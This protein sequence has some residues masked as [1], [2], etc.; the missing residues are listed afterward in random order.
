MVYNILY[1][2]TFLGQKR[3]EIFASFAEFLKRKW[4]GGGGGG[5]T[6]FRSS[7]IKLLS[8]IFQNKLNILIPLEKIPNFKKQIDQN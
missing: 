5:V 3:E 2:I 8:R 6:H 7:D 1:Q 4:G